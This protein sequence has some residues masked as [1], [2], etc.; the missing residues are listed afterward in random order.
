MQ[1]ITAS[2]LQFEVL[3]RVGA[4][5]GGQLRAGMSAMLVGLKGAKVA[6]LEEC[7]VCGEREKERELGSHIE[8]GT[9]ASGNLIPC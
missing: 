9:K 6:S 8:L 2:A 4:H 3:T 7:G 1:L 5:F